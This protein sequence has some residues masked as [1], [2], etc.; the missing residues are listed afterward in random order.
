MLVTTRWSQG[1]TEVLRCARTT[2]ASEASLHSHSCVTCALSGKQSP[3]ASLTTFRAK[4]IYEIHFK[5]YAYFYSLPPSQHP[6]PSSHY[7]LFFRGSLGGEGS[8]W[9]IMSLRPRNLQLCRKVR[10]HMLCLR[11]RNEP[12]LRRSSEYKHGYMQ[13]REPDVKPY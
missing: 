12:T 7:S 4:H 5:F 11:C 3:A 6:E 8:L 10:T 1:G 2:G 13:R 9:I